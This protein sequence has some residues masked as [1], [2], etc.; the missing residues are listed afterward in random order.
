MVIERIKKFLGGDREAGREEKG[1]IKQIYSL[2][3]IG[4]LEE[5]FSPSFRQEP[6]EE[7]RELRREINEM[8]D[9]I[10]GYEFTEEELERMDRSPI[11]RQVIRSRPL[12]VQEMRAA[13]KKLPTSLECEP[14]RLHKSLQSSLKLIHSIQR[15]HGKKMAIFFKEEMAELGGVLNRLSDIEGEISRDIKE[16]MRERRL[17]QRIVKQ[18]RELEETE[19]QL[20]N[21]EEELEKIEGEIERAEEFKL[22]K[23]EEIEK[24]K[25]SQK[26]KKHLEKREKLGKL[27][28]EKILKR[29]QVINHFGGLSRVLKRYHKSMLSSSAPGSLEVMEGYLQNPAEYIFEDKSLKGLKKLLK[30]MEEQIAR[31]SY[32]FKGKKKK[33][34]LRNIEGVDYSMLEK[35]KR[36]LAS[37]E[38]GIKKL[39][40]QLDSSKVEKKV[41]ILENKI[42]SHQKEI[43]NKIR[44]KESLLNLIEKK[45]GG[46]GGKKKKLQK[47]LSEYEGKKVVLEES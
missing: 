6:L 41:S 10:E 19:T 35:V 47:L 31:G 40:R 20:S 46:L 26:Y 11:H 21:L 36:G 7:L 33:K 30:A 16:N 42:D 38:E 22:K 15:N 1:E 44:E 23:E 9:R 34:A 43:E 45:R 4:A 27:K 5:R 3:E 24:I 18:K 12:F 2:E 17:V 8:L 28:E 32:G 13:A 25:S 37:C 39:E 14:E 29:N